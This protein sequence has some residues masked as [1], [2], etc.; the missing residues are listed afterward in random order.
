MIHQAEEIDAKQRKWE[1]ERKIMEGKI[2]EFQFV[3]NQKT[4]KLTET[5]T[6]LEKLSHQFELLVARKGTSNSKR[7]GVEWSATIKKVRLSS[8]FSH[9]YPI[10]CLGHGN[11]TSAE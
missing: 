9:T 1:N 8:K 11:G 5:E 4:Q 2:R 6:K 10:K 7:D 3:L